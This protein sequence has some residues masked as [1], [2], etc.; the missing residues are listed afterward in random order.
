[1]LSSV[2]SLEN[3]EQHHLPLYRSAHELR[4][5]Q[6]ILKAQTP[7]VSIKAV[8]QLRELIAQA[9]A[10]NG[11]LIQL[12]DCAESFY[13]CNQETTYAKL[14]FIDQIANFFQKKTGTQAIRVGRI[15]GQYAKPRSNPYEVSHNKKIYSYFGDMVNQAHKNH[16]TPDPWRMLLSYNCAASICHTMD[17]WNYGTD[18]QHKTYTSHEA[19]LL[20]YEQ[21][22]TRLDKKTG[23]YFNISTHFPWLGKRT[24]QS[25]QHINYLQK[26]ANPIAIKIGPDTSIK[27]LIHTVD[28]LDPEGL[29]GRITLIPRLGVQAVQHILPE[30][31]A[32]IKDTHRTVLWSCDPMHGNTEM[33]ASG[34]KVR[35]L[36]NIIQEIKHSFL[37]HKQMDS[38]LNAIH[39]EATYQN[40][41]ECVD[42]NIPSQNLGAGFKKNYKSLVD[43]RLNYAQTMHVMQSVAQH[44]IQSR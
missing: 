9:A 5:I 3:Q 32:A 6:N 41:T 20:N 29:P 35:V 7:L 17:Q 38:Q 27:D 12:G 28:E 25:A 26:I 39:L 13:E 11:F 2:Q 31:I 37:I 14:E 8:N 42:Y 23:L 4:H 40:V 22:L 18:K 10:G 34:V 36:N 24:V 15:A 44:Y 30:L 19:L 21:A 43:P 1:M 16:R 33:D